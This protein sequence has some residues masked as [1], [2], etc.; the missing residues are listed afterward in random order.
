M[1]KVA[2]RIWP[3]GLIL[4]CMGISKPE[5]RISQFT[6]LTLIDWLIPLY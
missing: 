6:I 3:T 1:L 5:T 2:Y 4:I